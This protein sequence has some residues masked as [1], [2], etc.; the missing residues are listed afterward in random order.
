MKGRHNLAFLII[1]LFLA[2]IPALSVLAAEKLKFSTAIRTAAHT[3]MP[4]IAAEEKGF[5]KAQGLEVEWVPFTAGAD[6]AR[7]IAGGAVNVGLYSAT[8]LVPAV[9]R[10]VPVFIV[11]DLQINNDFFLWVRPDSPLRSPGDLK[12]A[13]VGVPALGDVAHAYGLAISRALGMEKDIKFVG[14]G[15]MTASFAALK[16]GA[17]DGAIQTQFATAPLKY[18]GEVRALVSVRDYLPK[19]W[20]DNLIFSRRDFAAKE[21]ETVR[22]VVKAI[23][24]ATDFIMKSREWAI[25][26]MK[27]LLGH[28][29]ESAQG[30]YEL[31]KYGSDGKINKKGLENVRKF[32]IEYGVVPKEKAP[33]LEQL[34][35]EEFTG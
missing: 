33:P 28:S 7:A 32:M 26:R 21:P 19:D 30:T 6:M 34:Y 5:W 23:L 29:E 2:A 14:S 17:L 24:Q 1:S 35:T 27:A 9:S 8:G 18:K 10:G 13:K 11:A 12:G 20:M 15:G 4:P 3:A 22:R 25:E 31:L 16:T